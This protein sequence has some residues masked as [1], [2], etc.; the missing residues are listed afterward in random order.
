MSELRL[1]ED[2][3]DRMVRAVARVRERLQCGVSALEAAAVPYA[4]VGG[5][6]VAAWVA[7]VD[8]EAVETRRTS[9]S[10]SGVPILKR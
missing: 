6:A 4:V 5:H 1:T 2:I 9:M 10:S 8:A 3:L 7:T